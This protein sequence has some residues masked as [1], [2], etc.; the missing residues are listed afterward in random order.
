MVWDSSLPIYGSDTRLPVAG[1]RAGFS[2]PLRSERAG[3]AVDRLTAD[4]RPSLP[5][6]IPRSVSFIA[7]GYAVVPGRG[8]VQDRHDPVSPAP[9]ELSVNEVCPDR[10]GGL[11][12]P[13]KRF[14]R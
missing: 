2:K 9:Q 5:A 3:R 10:T 7:K 1:R 13:P 4:S 12:H 6:D 8:S 11:E 14:R